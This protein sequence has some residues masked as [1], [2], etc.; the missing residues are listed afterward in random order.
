MGCEGLL[1]GALYP[2]ADFATNITSCD[3]LQPGAGCPLGGA[4][5][6]VARAVMRAR[7]PRLDRLVLPL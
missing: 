3:D 7:G 2:F 5:G 1:C 6:R 4:P